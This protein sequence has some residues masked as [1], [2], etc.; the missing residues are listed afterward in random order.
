MTI[1]QTFARLRPAIRW[2]TCALVLGAA[3]HI[4]RGAPEVERVQLRP[5]PVKNLR[6]GT[7][8]VASRDLPDPNFIDTV[9]VLAQFSEKDGAMGLIV[10]RQT[11]VPL[12]RVVPSLKNPATCQCFS[13]GP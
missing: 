1:L 13:V 12:S 4:V 6:P 7:L 9:V 8:L 3:V 10:N 5:G 2:L 11:S